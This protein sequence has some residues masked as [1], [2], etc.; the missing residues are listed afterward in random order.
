[1][2]DLTFDVAP[3]INVRPTTVR[4]Y[5]AHRAA[6]DPDVFAW[7]RHIAPAA[8]CTRPVRLSGRVDTVE[9]VTG[10]LLATVDTSAMPDGLIYKPCG[11]RRTA[12]CPACARTYQRDAY[13]LLRAGLAGGKGV[14]TTVSRHPA[15]FATFTAPSFGPVHTR[16]V[17]RHTCT[18]R[19]R[20]DCRPEPCHARRATGLCPHGR[21]AVCFARHEPGDPLLGRALC[22]DCYDYDHQVVWNLFAGELWRRTKQAAERRLA[23]LAAHRGIPSVVVAGGDGHPR[24]VPPVRLSHGK[25][26]EF[27][28]RGA[29]HF[30][31]LLRLDGVDPHH[32]AAVV[33]PPAGFTSV[34]LEDAIRYAAAL[35][36]VDTPPHPE[37]PQGWPIVWGTEQLDVKH[38]TLTGA[39]EVTDSMVAGYLA[40]YATKST[41]VTGHT[42]T[43]ITAET[44]SLFADPGGDHVARLIDACW[45]LGRPDTPPAP[46]ARHGLLPGPDRRVRRWTCPGCGTPTRLKVCL[47]CDPSC[48]PEVVSQTPNGANGSTTVDMR[49]AAAYGR[50]RRWAHMLGFGGHFLTKARRYSV[51][52]GVLR[53]ARVDYRRAIDGHA[54]PVIRTVDHDDETTLIVGGLSFA[55]VGWHSTGDAALAATSASWPS[56]EIATRDHQRRRTA[57]PSPPGHGARTPAANLLARL[58]GSWRDALRFAYDLRV[59]FDNSQAE[60]D[61]RMV[62]LRQKISGCLRTV[63]GAATFCAIRSYLST[64]RKQGINALDTLTRLHNGNLWMPGTS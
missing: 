4:D 28:V 5:I 31:A 55:G 48:K 10:R 53:A 43:R 35:V 42:S 49:T 32:L 60:R 11:N 64:A 37:R 20:C 33:P 2:A 19:K 23:Q 40:K 56:T 6:T 24:K 9:E 22:L 3:W 58:G 18:N 59:P 26:A 45:R 13:Q 25:A 46:S 17:K 52:F 34:D 61:I 1:M 51:T 44:A 16:A 47:I 39:G 50:L 38:I 54:P 62:K 15:V 41:E 14:P 12:V 36:A 7:L 27:Q 8:A 63:T 30:H 21:P 29:V 57:N